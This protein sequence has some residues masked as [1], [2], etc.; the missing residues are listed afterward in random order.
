MRWGR[1][2]DNLNEKY[3]NIIEF[4]RRISDD[5]CKNKGIK[6]SI[7]IPSEDKL[8]AG[9]K[10]IGD[11]EYSIEIYP[12]CLNLDY[13]I[14]T[15]TKRYTADDL[16]TFFRFKEIG[17]FKRCED[18]TYR[19]D[20][21]NLFATVILLQIF[22]H[23]VGH[24]E[25]GYVDRKRDYVEFH[26]DEKG[27]Y[28]KQEQEMVADWIS[29]KQVF[30]LIY[31]DVI[32][33]KVSDIDEWIKAIQQLIML[34]WVSLT[35]EFQIFDSKY[36]EQIDDFSLL[37]HPYPAVRL[38]YSIEA[39]AEEVVDILNILYGLDDDPAEKCMHL[40]VDDIYILIQSFMQITNSPIDIKKNEKRILECYKTLREIPYTDDYEKNEFLHLEP[41]SASYLETIDKFLRADIS[42]KAE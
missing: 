34:Y 36:V 12:A 17:I 20:L 8:N 32:Y 38:L 11:R 37:T 25:A 18:D 33:D 1:I 19:E 9:V 15:I 26:S 40:I 35:I 39:M 41:P 14:A 24:I 4:L 22:W 7:S 28:S 10:R 13:Q 2:M 3:T 5:Y 31:S 42:T 21:N 16:Q 29:T 6:I 23:E 27:C 30:N